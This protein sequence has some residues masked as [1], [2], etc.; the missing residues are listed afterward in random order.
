LSYALDSTEGQPAGHGIRCCWIGLNICKAVGLSGSTLSD[1][2]YAILFKDIGCSS[3]AARI[4]Q[5]F[6]VDDIDFK[7]D[8][9]TVNESLPQVLQFV[10][11]H[12]GFKSGRAE[13]FR[14][15]MTTFA[16][17]GSIIRDLVETRCQ[18]GADIVRRMRFSE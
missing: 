5:L 4:C 12:T 6:L 11:S 10:L 2:Y 8:I 15:L 14:A 16:T 13:H 3:N 9:K 7:R 17:G 1:L 18:R